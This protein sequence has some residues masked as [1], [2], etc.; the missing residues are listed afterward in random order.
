MARKPAK[1]LS[2]HPYQFEP[3]ELNF[4]QIA[5]MHPVLDDLVILSSNLEY[6]L[7]SV[8]EVVSPEY[9]LQLLQAHP[10]AIAKDKSQYYCI[11]NPRLFQIAKIVLPDSQLLSFREMLNPGPESITDFGQTDFYLSHLLFSLRLQDGNDQ[12]CRI[13]QQLDDDLKREVTPGIKHQTVLMELL[14][15]SRNLSYLRR[16][17]SGK[18]NN[19]RGD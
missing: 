6:L 5:G 2:K 9:F 15:A 8:R 14:N 3:I 18:K 12:L 19:D 17:K 13:W 16:K 4:G 10:L 7:D 1:S 11:S